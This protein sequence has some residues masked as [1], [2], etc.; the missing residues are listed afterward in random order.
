[1][2]GGTCLGI[3]KAASDEQKA[4]AY[5][6]INWCLSTPEGAAL[7]RDAA[8][9]ITSDITIA[10]EEF[11]VRDDEDFFGGQE[12]SKLYY[13]DVAPAVEIP[14]AT[15]YDNDIIAVR[16]DVAQLVMD[17]PSMTV[18]D[19]VAAAIEE[20]SQLITDDTVTIE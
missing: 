12:I 2:H 18:E 6:F 10:T 9:Y 16:N 20:L 17:D 13:Q 11:C 5:D 15:A 14:P 4:A 3:T 8:G 7:N 1:M 19:A